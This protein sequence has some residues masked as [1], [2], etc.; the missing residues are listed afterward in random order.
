MLTTTA[1]TLLMWA[2][3]VTPLHTAHNTV[4]TAP[5]T[6]DMTQ[7]TLHICKTVHTFA[8]VLGDGGWRVCGGQ[9]SRKEGLTM[10]GLGLIR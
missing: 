8:E 3:T 5:I 7:H 10:R 1:K 4:H 6:V 9:Y 2:H